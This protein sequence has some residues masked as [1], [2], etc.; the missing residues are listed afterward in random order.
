MIN[1]IIVILTI[2]LISAC[3]HNNDSNMHKA[4]SLRSSRGSV[5]NM[6]F[7]PNGEIIA[8][9]TKTECEDYEIELRNVKTGKHLKSFKGEKNLLFNDTSNL[10]LWISLSWPSEILHEKYRSERF[11]I[12]YNINIC[13]LNKIKETSL[14]RHRHGWHHYGHRTLLPGDRGLDEP[15]SSLKGNFMINPFQCSPQSTFGYGIFVTNNFS[16]PKEVSKHQNT[17]RNN[18]KM[19]LFKNI[20][21]FTNYNGI[22]TWNISTKGRLDNWNK[23]RIQGIKKKKIPSDGCLCYNP[24]KNI[25]AYYEND[26]SEIKLYQ[27]ENNFKKIQ[28]KEEKKEDDNIM[29]LTDRL[30]K[31]HLYIKNL[32][33]KLHNAQFKIKELE[34][35]CESLRPKNEELKF[36][37]LTEC[38]KN[39]L[40]N[41]SNM[42]AIIATGDV[43]F[44]NGISM[45]NRQS[46]LYQNSKSAITDNHTD[47]KDNHSSLYHNDDHSYSHKQSSIADNHNILHHNEDNS[48][49]HSRYSSK[50]DNHSVFNNNEESQYNYNEDNSYNNQLNDHSYREDN[51]N[52]IKSDNHSVKKN[53]TV[54]TSAQFSLLG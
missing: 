39:L 19:E 23:N 7:S 46:K 45:Q 5:E 31:S 35:E 8:L 29:A 43:T 32:E 38:S 26:V 42:P 52:D 10:F 34:N 9:A 54:N 24:E 2:A 27:S 44:S 25:I 1:K 53:T 15:I 4:I 28:S 17:I 50:Q 21:V 20:L 14:L 49:K 12:S 40:Q 48:H 18:L 11:K 36:K 51:S 47:L 37:F 13:D 41:K 6:I 22:D 30:I 16:N 3:N 33:T